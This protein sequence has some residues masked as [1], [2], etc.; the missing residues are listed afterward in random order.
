MKAVQ[1][2]GSVPRYAYSMI[3]GPLSRKAYYDSLSNIV[4]RDVAPPALP[5]QEWVRV[6]TKYAGFCGSDKN[7]VQLH[8]SPATSPFA[9][10]P[11]TIGHENCGY[12]AEMGDIAAERLASTVSAGSRVLV[13][14]L[15]SC[16]QRGIDPLC[17]A[18]ARGDYSL[19]Y[20]FTEGTVSP[21]F[22]IGSCRDTGGGWSEEFVV[23]YTQLI[24]IPDN[25]SSEDAVLVDAFCSSL[26]PV[27]RN[28]PKDDS[29][30]LV[31]GCGVIGLS[32]IA[33]I[34]AL[35]G[36]ARIIALAKYPFQ[37]E[38]AK[39]CGAD[40]VVYMSP[41]SDYYSSLA[42]ALDA[43]LLDPMLGKRVVVGGADI[44]YDCVG[45]STSIDDALRFTLP[46]GTMVLVGLAAFPKGV[47]WTPIWMK[48]VQVRG[49]FWCSTEEFEGR[50]MRTYEVAMEL[51]KTGRLQL[52]H[53]LTH[54]FRLE[55]YKE[56]IEAN[57]NIGRTGL[58]KSAFEF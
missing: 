56:A 34:R 32:A 46:H 40:E 16:I 13:D 45:S 36:K 14:P 27:M 55:D 15:L 51:L 31:I 39:Q 8:D 20:N 9:S 48:E 58:I 28:F 49:S 41:S 30:V 3:L 4:F 7:L 37:G 44:V 26:H 33:A 47:D 29:T 17:P 19:C 25:V 2:E 43:K 10:F 54:K 6:K 42:K 11:F 21:G 23:H 18:C 50:R 12:L 1:F 5:N 22:S 53:L 57:L 52:A 24:P 35:G 38:T